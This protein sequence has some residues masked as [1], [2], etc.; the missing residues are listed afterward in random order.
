MGSKMISMTIR[1]L[2]LSIS[3]DFVVLQEAAITGKVFP[4]QNWATITGMLQAMNALT[5]QNDRIADFLSRLNRVCSVLFAI[6]RLDNTDETLAS[7]AMPSGIDIFRQLIVT[8]TRVCAQII[9]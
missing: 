9:I 3:V 8:S 2:M 5:I 7:F 4:Y 6:L 1:K